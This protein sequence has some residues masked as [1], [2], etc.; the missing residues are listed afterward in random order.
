[1]IKAVSELTAKDYIYCMTCKMYVD[2]FA[3]DHDINDAG[4]E[5]CKWR[6]VIKKELKNCIADCI[7][8]KCGNVVK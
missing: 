4:H 6:Y 5:K 3:Y 7:S 8:D 1:M 2:F